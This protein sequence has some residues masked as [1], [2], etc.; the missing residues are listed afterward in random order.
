MKLVKSM[1]LLLRKINV[2]SLRNR[3]GVG[4]VN[5]AIICIQV[6]IVNGSKK[7]E[8]ALTI[9]AKNSTL[10][11]TVHF[12]AEDFVKIKIVEWNMTPS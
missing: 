10:K 8:S 11:K 2:G 7:L 9:S 12:G 3:V 5:Y 6:D 1:L 4:L